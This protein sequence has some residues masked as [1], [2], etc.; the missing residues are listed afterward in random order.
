MDRSSETS[1][2][3]ADIPSLHI[4]SLFCSVYCRKII[5]IDFYFKGP[6][7]EVGPSQSLNKI[8]FSSP[9][10]LNVNMSKSIS[11]TRVN[12][13]WCKHANANAGLLLNFWFS[14]TLNHIWI[15][16]LILNRAEMQSNKAS[17]LKWLNLHEMCK[18]IC[19]QNI[20]FKSPW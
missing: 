11:F 17:R 18:C 1:E 15:L 13:S 7:M 12:I 2:L 3:S 9:G 20:Y 8:S 4:V 16:K 6:I 19:I 5:D 10:R 14:V